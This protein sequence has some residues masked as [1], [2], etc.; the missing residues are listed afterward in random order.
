MIGRRLIPAV[1][2]LVLVASARVYSQCSIV[3]LEGPDRVPTGEILKISAKLAIESPSPP[4]FKWEI[5]AGT[6]T[7]DPTG[8]TIFV[9]T[10]GL[11]GQSITTTVKVT[12]IKTDCSKE[13]S[14]VTRVEGVFVCGLAFDEYGDIKFRDEEARLDNFAI[15]LLNLHDS[16]GQILAYAGQR[17]YRNESAERLQ[18]AKN[19]LVKI[20]HIDSARIITVDGGH[21]QNFTLM[22]LVIPKGA[23][24]VEADTTDL[25]A[26]DK[27][28]F[29][30]PRQRVTKRRKNR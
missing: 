27:L 20:R 28:D 22:L 18:R 3:S 10:A 1:L 7:S 23:S 2:V 26:A 17:T 4:E 12:G 11:G 6:I 13:A 29:T 9:E 15:Q 30:K 21:R 14:L 24:P 8:P 5:S 19:Y 16:R 25:I